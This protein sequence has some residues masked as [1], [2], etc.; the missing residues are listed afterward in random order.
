MFY[1]QM[2]TD[3]KTAFLITHCMQE[4]IVDKRPYQHILIKDF[5]CSSITDGKE[6]VWVSVNTVNFCDIASYHRSYNII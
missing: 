5:F 1:T 3:A 6:M 4:K 2:L